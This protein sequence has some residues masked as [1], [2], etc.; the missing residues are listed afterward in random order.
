MKGNGGGIFLKYGKFNYLSYSPLP[1]CFTRA[2]DRHLWACQRGTV[3]KVTLWFVSLSQCCNNQVVIYALMLTAGLTVLAEK[4]RDHK[5][6]VRGRFGVH[7]LDLIPRWCN[8]C[9]HADSRAHRTG[10]ERQRPQTI[11]MNPKH[12]IP[13]LWVLFLGWT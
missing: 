6:Y 8:L 5:P 2:W 11:A 13:T 10:R 4:D 7:R 1:S 3:K 12:G 9:F